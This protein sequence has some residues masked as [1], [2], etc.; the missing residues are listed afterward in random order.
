MGKRCHVLVPQLLELLLIFAE[1]QI[2]KVSRPLVWCGVNHGDVRLLLWVL[3]S[4]VRGSLAVH[5]VVCKHKL[6]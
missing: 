3:S 2:V 6:P 4:D 1:I 5:Q